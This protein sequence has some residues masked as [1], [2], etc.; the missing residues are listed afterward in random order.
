MPKPRQRVCLEAG[1]KLDLNSLIRRQCVNPGSYTWFSSIWT[2]SYG[3][4]IASASF[5]ACMVNHYGSKLRIQMEDME[6]TIFLVAKSRTFGGYQWY[7][8]CPATNCCCSVLWKPPGATHFR[9]RQGWGR[10]VAY[11]SQFL[12]PDNRAHRGKAKIKARLIADLNPDEWELPPKPK[13]MRWRTYNRYV[14]RFDRYEDI[15]TDGIEGLA[16]KLLDEKYSQ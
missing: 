10:K 9:S 4:E 7:F 14:E 3:E 1:L 15:L 11:A 16:A 12:D 8:V 5:T 2:N 6:Q 13:W